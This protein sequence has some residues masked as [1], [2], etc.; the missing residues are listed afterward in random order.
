MSHAA[1]SV[2]T[3]G[4]YVIFVGTGL[5]LIPD[6]V[7][8]AFNLPATEDIW[9]RMMGMMTLFIGVFQLQMARLEL[10]ELFG[11]TVL[12]RL[13]VVGFVLAFIALGLA[14]PAFLMIAVVD[15]LGALWTWWALRAG[16]VSKT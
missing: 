7:L 6:M 4:L 13:S 10:R 11:L 8:S 5:I 3:A 9:I 2:Y 14:Q 1:V 15:V 16:E 12:L